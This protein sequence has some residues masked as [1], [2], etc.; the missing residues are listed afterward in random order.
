MAKLHIFHDADMPVYY[1]YIPGDM[2]PFSIKLLVMAGSADDETFGDEGL[3]H[4]FEHVPF[5]GT[6]HFPHGSIELTPGFSRNGG[7]I[8]AYTST[9][10]T[11]F[12]AYV[13]R[14]Y[15]HHALS[16]VIDLVA[17]PLLRDE[18]IAAER[19]IIK[20]EI[21]QRTSSA[22]GFASHQLPQ[23]LWGDHPFGH[24]VAGSAD[25]LDAMTSAHL[26][27]V[28]QRFY[29]KATTSLFV[30]GSIP[31]EE[32]REL[33]HDAL[34][35]IPKAVG[36]NRWLP[37]SY[38][39]MPQWQPGRTTITTSFDSSLVYMLFPVSSSM[40]EM[41]GVNR[42]EAV[43]SLLATGGLSAPLSRTLRDERQL[44][45]STYPTGNITRDGGFVGLAAHCQK[46][47]IEPVIEAFYD[48]LNLP[49][50]RSEERWHFCFSGMEGRFAMRIPHP[51]VATDEMIESLLDG[52]V[53]L[54]EDEAFARA[55][56]VTRDDACTILDKT[57][58]P[59]DARIIVFEGV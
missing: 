24:S 58:T 56:A 14:Q 11:V 7:S 39:A 21:R 8:N 29:T 13:A 45:Y 59:D 4:W 27:R 3:M 40:W 5:R 1:R 26:R 31:P 19:T 54:D 50:L 44:C 42:Y 30:S 34:A 48:V 2:N 53:V 46:K 16:A 57:Y 55:A 9:V 10:M 28:H 22:T 49:E 41:N 43:G 47:N 36:D 38:G 6:E 25:T 23:L 37:V 20:E 15:I 35:V 33:A 17:N 12:H 32:L 51:D 18:D 52:G